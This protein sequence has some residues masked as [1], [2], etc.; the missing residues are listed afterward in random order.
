MAKALY[1]EYRPQNFSDVLGQD[2][3]VN[4]LKNQVKS[5][6]IS[7]AY[8]FAGERGCGKTTCA[9][10]FAKAINCLNPID[11]SPCGECENCKSI[12][13]ESTMDVVEMDAASNRRIDDIRNLK[14]TVVYP[15]NNL[16][17]KVY[18][19]DEAHMI[20]REAFNA[21]LKI[22]EEPPSHLVFILATTE[23]E[24]I[25]KTIL[26]RV[27]KFEFNKIG[28][29]DIIKQIDIILSDRNITI[30]QE[31]KE[32]IVKKAKGA[33][34]DALSILDQVLSIDKNNFTLKD[35]EN[36]LGLVDFESLDKLI[37]NIISYNQKDSLDLLFDLRNNN[38]DDKDI[39]DGLVGY[40]RD[41]MIYKTS[42]N[43]KYIENLDYLDLIK[44]K[45]E[46]ISSDRLVSYLEILNDYSN[47][48]KISDN[49]ALL[50]EMAILRLI[51]LKDDENI[52][53]RLKKLEENNSSNSIDIINK[54][55]DKK[56]ENINLDNF[57]K[58]SK[59]SL[60]YEKKEEK[61]IE[62]LDKNEKIFEEKNKDI[63]NKEIDNKIEENFENKHSD[64]EDIESEKTFEN[65]SLDKEEE[66]IFL[67]EFTSSCSPI[68]KVW[69]RDEGF[70]YDINVDIFTIYFTNNLYYQF[71]EGSKAKIK[72]ILKN[73]SGRDFT[74]KVSSIDK[75][76]SNKN[77][78]IR[79]SKNDSNDDVMKKLEKIFG[80]NLIIEE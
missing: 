67:N 34:R 75:K 33:M 21:L 55:V 73:V 6:Q 16:K 23:I 68:L 58:N 74:I 56:F 64:N 52:L 66:N 59:P 50:M 48:M 38:K 9:K 45:I 54:L 29:E 7:H 17:Y 15:P 51:N 14:E 40:F 49:S 24:K 37:A 19:I 2:R 13:E 5:G 35:V 53:S 12:E 60:D 47:R 62:K 78:S 39:L 27:Q 3:V 76:K 1:R 41:I 69:I 63:E 26:S 72:E 80:N 4:V 36:I 57:I 70:N 11:S 61:N 79:E 43:R 18:I 42:Q 46:K 30:E 10:I 31:A 25:P 28:R 20:T 71:L 77:N 44:E 8:L 65:I 22:M 32:L